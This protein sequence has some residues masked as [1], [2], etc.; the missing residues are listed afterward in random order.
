MSIVTVSIAN[1][2]DNIVRDPAQENVMNAHRKSVY[3]F[4]WLINLKNITATSTKQ[5]II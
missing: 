2:L 4:L 3:Y 5:I 1:N